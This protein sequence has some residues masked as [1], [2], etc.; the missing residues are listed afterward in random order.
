MVIF[1]FQFEEN[2]RIS[3]VC[4]DLQEAMSDIQAKEVDTLS[5]E[6]IDDFLG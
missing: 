2:S 5:L 4:E 1:G 3:V 6:Y